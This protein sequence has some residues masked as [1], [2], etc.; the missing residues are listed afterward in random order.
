MRP[1]EP[2]ELVPVYF[3]RCR[4]TFW[5]AQDDHGPPRPFCG[6]CPSRFL[7]NGFDFLD[8]VVQS[9][10]HGLVHALTVRALHKTG[11]IA[12]ALEH[13]LQLLMTDASQQGWIVD[14]ITVEAEDG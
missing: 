9:G 14:L 2:F 4:P 8:A 11:R 1:P 10:R 12:V 3:G 5:R 7:L 6:A 13:I